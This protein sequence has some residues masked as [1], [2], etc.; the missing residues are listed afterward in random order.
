MSKFTVVYQSSHVSGLQKKDF[1]TKAEVEEFLDDEDDEIAME[2]DA[3]DYFI[4]EG[5]KSVKLG[6]VDKT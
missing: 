5:G 2:G 3:Q 6:T 1:K 4:I